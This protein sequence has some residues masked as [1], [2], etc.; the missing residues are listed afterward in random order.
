MWPTH[1]STQVVEDRSAFGGGSGLDSVWLGLG[2]EECLAGA[3]LG[4]NGGWQIVLDGDWHV[5]Q[6]LC[7]AQ[8]PSPMPC[9]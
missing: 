8:G 9:A 2:T 6:R 4:D 5:S 3:E 1:P 7:L